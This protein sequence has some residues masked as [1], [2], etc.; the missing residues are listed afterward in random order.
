LFAFGGNSEIFPH[1]FNHIAQK[2]DG[3]TGAK[4]AGENAD[5]Y[6]PA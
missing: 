1:D 6:C 2:F 4:T 3:N 5:L